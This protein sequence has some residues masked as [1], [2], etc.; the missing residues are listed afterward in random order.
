M[1]AHAAIICRELGIPTIIGIDGLLERVRDGDVVEV[2]DRGPVSLVKEKAGPVPNAA[3]WPK[4]LALAD[5]IGAKAFNLGR[6]R[7]LGISRAGLCGG[8]L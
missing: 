7:S 3:F 8:G 1:T 2:D 5:R 4:D 6:V